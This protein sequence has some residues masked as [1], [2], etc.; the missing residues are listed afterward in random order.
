M[1][2]GIIEKVGTVRDVQVRGPGI[3]IEIE[4]GYSDL[5]L[6]ESV[7][8][9]GVCLTVVALGQ[10][11]AFDVSSESL[12]R[13][14][15]GRAKEGSL[16][17][18]ERAMRADGRFSGHIVQGHVDGVGQIESW[19]EQADGSRAL[20]VSVPEAVARYCV[21]K[22]SLTVQGVSLTINRIHQNRV[23]I[24]IVPHTW[25]HTSFS[26]LNAGSP[27]NL[28]ADVIAKYVEKLLCR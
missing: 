23:D 26:Q 20:R 4:T 14:A 9:D 13:T 16:V 22:G 21:E 11:T 27:V 6:G 3:R 2:T 18:L 28:E 1:F 8:V 19:G 10:N 17:N 5:T 7:A 12:E 25:A 15:L 24:M